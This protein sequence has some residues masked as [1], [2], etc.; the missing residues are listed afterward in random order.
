MTTPDPKSATALNEATRRVID[1]VRRSK[2][3]PEAMRVATAALR[4]VADQLE[5]DAVDGP[6]AQRDLVFGG[7]NAPGVGVMSRATISACSSAATARSRNICF[8]TG[9]LSAA[10]ATP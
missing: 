4:A 10:E 5:P 1:L 7:L 6:F 9:S 2:A 3:D 8:M